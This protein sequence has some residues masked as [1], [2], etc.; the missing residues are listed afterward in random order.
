MA[1]R[2]KYFLCT[3]YLFIFLGADCERA[4]YFQDIFPLPTPAQ[5]FVSLVILISLE[6]LMG[7]GAPPT[8]YDPEISIYLLV[9]CVPKL[10]VYP[11]IN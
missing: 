6:S 11:D 9:H 7:K 5:L 1:L 2:K 10:C 4:A 8:I 3:I